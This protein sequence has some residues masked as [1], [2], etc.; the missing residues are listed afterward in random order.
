MIEQREPKASGPRS[1]T[2]E[3][4]ADSACKAMMNK[5]PS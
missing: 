4:E 3:I 5:V 2:K 1:G